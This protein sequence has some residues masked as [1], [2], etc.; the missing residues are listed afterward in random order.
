MASDAQFHVTLMDP[1]FFESLDR[2][3]PTD[4]YWKLVLPLLE[5]GKWR[6]VFG[7]FW[8]NVLPGSDEPLTDGW[9]IHISSTVENA[10][11]TLRRVAPILVRHDTGFK[12]CS[13]PRMLALS[14]T[15]N[16]PRTGAGKFMA[17]YP[18][19]EDAFKGLIE[20]CFAATQGLTGPFILSDRPFKD[21]RVV[22][23]RYGE[24]RARRIVNP[25]GIRVPT[26]VSPTG[27]AYSDERVAY[28]KLPAWI[29][30][31]FSVTP[32]PSQPGEG[33]VLLHDRYQVK[34]ALKF[35]SVG[36][37]YQAFDTRS[38]RDVIIRE[39]R[40][41]LARV[42]TG[43][44]AERLLEKEARILKA[45]S[46]SGLFPEFVDLFQEWEHSFL[47]QEKLDAESLWG[48]A[49]NFAFGDNASPAAMFESIRATAR[50]IITGL[51]IVHDR[52]IVLRDL[53][54]TNV[55]FTKEGKVKFIDL[56]FAYEI[57]GED[58]P[59]AGWTPGYASKDQLAVQ[60]PKKEED[61]YALGVL[62]LDMI[63]F[64]AP[65]YSLNRDGMLRSLAMDLSDCR[66]PPEIVGVIEGLTAIEAVDRWTPARAMRELDSLP[67]PRDT[68]PLFPTEQRALSFAEPS[69]GLRAQ[70]ASTIGGIGDY[71]RHHSDF[72]RDDRLWPASGEI[73]FTN[74]VHLQYGACGT[75]YFLLSAEGTVPQESMRWIIDHLG[76]KALPPGLMAGSAGVALFLCDAGEVALA[77]RVIDEAAESATVYS[78]ANLY[79]GAAGWG[80]GNLGLWARTKDPQYLTNALA[81]GHQ[82][83]SKSTES[84]KGLSWEDEGYT[85]LGFGEGQSGTALFLLYL[86][87]AT[88]DERFRDAGIRALD[89]DLSYAVEI[90][91]GVLWFPHI[92]ARPGDPKSP[93]I[94]FGTAGI[95]SAVLRAFLITGEQRFLDWAQRCAYTVSRRFTNKLWHDYGMSGYIELLLDMYHY[96]GEELHLHAAWHIAERLVLHRMETPEGFAYLGRELL[97]LSC[98]FAMGSAGIGMALHRTM[99][100]HTPRLFLPD[101]LIN[102]GR[103][104]NTTSTPLL[105]VGAAS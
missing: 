51:S 84:D 98:D 40:P 104:S 41:M 10:E 20:E 97:R 37:I 93:H 73:F 27:E 56:E 29:Q 83:L 54:K 75:G 67:A 49:M 62:L 8:T 57:G 72:G 92:A 11:E 99:N 34:L 52:G 25:Y 14:L 70:V 63:A 103:N 35:S 53:T 74:P 16:W 68:T 22:F 87:S 78:F 2:Y 91:F 18:R 24:H 23:Y 13:D 80:I 33:G 12:F 89:F 5:A 48:Y 36:G 32:P 42:N 77:R 94:R 26:L 55:L 81:T 105:E 76:S 90:P 38:Q 31:P 79:Y 47:V 59:V 86:Y 65:G 71:I 28:F 82:L 1:W 6:P 19:S 39:A 60:Q 100:P 30:D 4:A 43:Y 58:P 69:D 7:G 96:T 3:K 66:Q 101:Q 45:L 64:T 15:K 95:G 44:D 17:I 46:G 9:K 88:G 102:V 50:E 85:K 61:Y 21:S